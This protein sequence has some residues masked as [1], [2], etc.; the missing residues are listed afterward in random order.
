ML[1]LGADV[2][3][4]VEELDLEEVILIGHSM[5]GPIVLEA[6]RLMPERVIGVIGVDTLQ[7]ADFK[8][9]PGQAEAF[10]EPFTS[11]FTGACNR[12]VAGM[13][14]EGVDATLVEKVRL[15]MCGG[16][17]EIGTTLMGQ[18]SDYNLGAALAAV[19]IPVKCVNAG[20]WPTNIEA[21]RTYN[22]TFDAVIMDGPGHFLMMEVPEEFNA[23]LEAV[24]AEISASD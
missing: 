16:D 15:D 21:N 24:V 22:E 10:V 17:P 9:E 19:T 14:H 11:D 4:V 6:A 18:Y 5:G 7:D 1:G 3:A 20:M 8:Y 13:F 2:K 12:F 23:I